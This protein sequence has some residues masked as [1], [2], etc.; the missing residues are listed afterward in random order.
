MT[1]EEL[2]Q[3]ICDLKDR[4]MN[5]QADECEGLR[6]FR[7]ALTDARREAAERITEINEEREGDGD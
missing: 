4:W 7:D 6:E 2:E 1:F 5:G 3:E